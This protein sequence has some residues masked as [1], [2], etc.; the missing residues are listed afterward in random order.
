MALVTNDPNRQKAALG[1]IEWFLATDNN[2]TWNNINKSIPT[3][4]SSFQQLAGEDPYWVFLTEQL[5]NARPHPDF[6]GYDQIGRILQQA[7]QQVISGEATPEE[8]TATAIDAFTQ[9]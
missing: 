6:P 4:D 1:L 5:N 7:V 8:A 9:Q 2:A 3:R